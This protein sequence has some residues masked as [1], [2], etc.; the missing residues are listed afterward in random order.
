MAPREGDPGGATK[1][2]GGS[3]NGTLFT[4][5]LRCTTHAGGTSASHAIT[6]TNVGDAV[7]GRR[8]DV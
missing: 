1:T 7:P 3:M 8:I 5:I 2:D 6:G 4:G